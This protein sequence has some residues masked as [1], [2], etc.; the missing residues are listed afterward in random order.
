MVKRLE[1]L[2]KTGGEL[3]SNDLDRGKI[4]PISVGLREGEIGLLEAI[5]AKVGDL[6]EGQPVARN[7]IMR[8]AIRDFLEAYLSGEKTTAEL[9][10][11]FETPEK[12]KPK[13]K[14]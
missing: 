14:F 12:P 4:K 11:L 2:R 8:I 10:D 6:L 1:A 9:A 5:G 7:A 13:L 3:T